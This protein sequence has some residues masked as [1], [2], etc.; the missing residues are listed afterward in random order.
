M[1]PLVFFNG[2]S[3]VKVDYD[4]SSGQ[5]I[6]T[7]ENLDKV[8]ITYKFNKLDTKN[9]RVSYYLTLDSESDNNQI[10]KRF[11]AIESSVRNLFWKEVKVEVYFNN[12]L[13]YPI[14]D[15]KK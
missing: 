13:K 14:V 3:E 4:F 8:D 12:E 6:D 2:V 7:E 1:Y 15:D 9:F 11:Q 5:L 10:D